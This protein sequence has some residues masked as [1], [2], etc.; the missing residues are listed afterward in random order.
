MSIRP[1]VFLTFL[2]L[3]LVPLVLLALVN[4]WNSVRIAEATL[5]SDQEA[6]LA[7][8]KNQVSKVIG[9]DQNELIKL[10]RSRTLLDY[11]RLGNHSNTSSPPLQSTGKTETRDLNSQANPSNALPVEL[12][13]RL[14]SVLNARAHFASISLFDPNRH[15]LF[16][17]EHREA[18]G[19]EPIVFY[20]RDFLSQQPQPDARVWTTQEATPLSSSAASTPSGGHM[21]LTVAVLAEKQ[22]VRTPQGALVGELKV[23]PIFSEAAIGTGSSRSLV[24]NS[25]RD[26][27][28]FIVLD[29]TGRILYHTNE[30]LK[31]QSASESMPYF[32]PVANHMLSSEQGRQRFTAPGGDEYSTL[33]AQIP[34]LDVS[35]AIASNDDQAIV[36][37]RRMG[38]MGLVISVLLGLVAAVLL[39]L[40]WQHNARG[41][42]RVTEGVVA[43][44]GGRLDHRIEARSSDDIRL[45]AENVNIVT[46]KMRDQIAREAETRQFQSFVRLSAILTHDLKNA[47]EALSLTVTNM[48]RHF[49]NH[50]FRA[51]AMKTLRSATEN[52]KALVARLSNPVTT[53]SGEHKRPMPVDIVPMLKRVISMTAEPARGQH[54]IKINLPPSLFALVDVER[55]DKVVENLIINALEAMAGKNGT[56]TIEAGQIEDGKP[57]FS[58]VDTGEGMSLRFVEERLFHP[59]AT[60]KKRGVGLG[61]YTCREVVRANGGSIDVDSQEGAGTTF[62]VVLPSAAIDGRGNKQP[63]SQSHS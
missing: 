32:L 2:G 47:I 27:G 22:D 56:L 8:F 40:Y 48:E 13:V 45:L 35:V 31:H 19:D 15:P 43:I 58:V 25:K 50:E 6:R 55:M 39:M 49:D 38:R 41:I 9:Q 10:S 17:A 12:R 18:G 33:Y 7:D 20:T 46:E 61:L 54:E 29:R 23:D 26:H 53:L 30:A 36:G 62:R 16:V 34:S 24:S 4:Y 63:H 59:F 21:S 57:F 44:A 1:K 14:A 3:C 37:A 60:T 28:M 11:I 51:D 5:Q 52:L 42:E